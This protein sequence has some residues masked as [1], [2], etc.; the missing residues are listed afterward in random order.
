[1]IW[2]IGLGAAGLALRLAPQVAWRKLGLVA[3]LIGI[4]LIG[5]ALPPLGDVVPQI[6]FW[7]MATLAVVA[8]G[9]AVT[10][11]SPVY[12]AIWFAVSL[13]GTAGLFLLQGAHFL[14]IATI[15][16]YAGAIVVTFLFVLMLAQPEGHSPYDRISWA[17]FA[18]PIATVGVAL[19]LGTLIGSLP[20]FSPVAMPEEILHEAHVARLGGELFAKHL[21]SVEVVGTILLAAL[22]GAIAIVIQG[23]PR[24]KTGVREGVTER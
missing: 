1:M 23:N 15:V 4:A 16:V 17:G 9:A 20:E 3:S 7:L 21:V 18:I 19:F 13:L 11:R 2:G 22:V 12:A 8:S 14:G 24:R 10:S 5:V 6:L